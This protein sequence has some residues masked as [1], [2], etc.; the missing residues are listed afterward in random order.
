MHSLNKLILAATTIGLTHNE[1]RVGVSKNAL[2]AI[3]LVSNRKLWDELKQGVFEFYVSKS[4][5]LYIK[6]PSLEDTGLYSDVRISNAGTHKL[7]YS[8]HT[9]NMLDIN[10]CLIMVSLKTILED[11]QKLNADDPDK[12]TDAI[13]SLLKLT[14][15]DNWRLVLKSMVGITL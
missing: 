7:L 14:H 5:E 6:F 1:L 11:Y 10:D 2:V 3:A 9:V 13:P 8:N 12:I 4:N 15:G